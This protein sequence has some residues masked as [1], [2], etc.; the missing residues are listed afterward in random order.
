MCNVQRMYEVTKTVSRKGKD[1]IT[2]NEAICDAEKCLVPAR[3]LIKIIEDTTE[4][5]ITRGEPS[6]FPFSF[7][8][9]LDGNEVSNCLI[10]GF[11]GYV[12]RTSMTTE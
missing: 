9:S 8:L 4:Q 1:L 7:P 3:N 10:A 12:E 5:I 6:P 11:R 2:K